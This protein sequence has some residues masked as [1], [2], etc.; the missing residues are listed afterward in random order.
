MPVGEL[1]DKDWERSLKKNC[2]NRIWLEATN[3]AGKE[4]NDNVPDR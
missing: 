2:K 1:D 3:C 4:R